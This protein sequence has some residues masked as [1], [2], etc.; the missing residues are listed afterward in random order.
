MHTPYASTINQAADRPWPVQAAFG[1]RSGGIDLPSG[2][3]NAPNGQEYGPYREEPMAELLEFPDIE[4]VVS[5]IARHDDGLCAIHGHHPALD[6]DALLD[7]GAEPADPDEHSRWKITRQA[8]D[9]IKP[10]LKER[11]ALLTRYRE[12]RSYKAALATLR[13]RD[14]LFERTMEVMERLV[15][16]LPH[17]VKVL[18]MPTLAREFGPFLDLYKE[19]RPVAVAVESCRAHRR[20]RARWKDEA[21]R[22]PGSVVPGT[23][24]RE[25]AA[26]E[27]GELVRRVRS[28]GAREGDLLRYLELTGAGETRA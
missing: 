8:F 19:L 15:D 25:S 17:V 23:D 13:R 26:R 12:G 2:H 5:H 1:P 16:E 21:R 3:F 18:A 9:S 10:F 4:D 28:G 22:G 27:L 20:K 7:C 14:P 11:E 6:W 24:R